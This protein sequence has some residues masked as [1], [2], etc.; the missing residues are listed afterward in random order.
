LYF[1][2]ALSGLERNK[3]GKAVVFMC[4]EIIAGGDFNLVLDGLKRRKMWKNQCL[5]LME[6]SQIYS[7]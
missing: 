4:R 2:F 1:G 3:A 5:D 6:I 7:G